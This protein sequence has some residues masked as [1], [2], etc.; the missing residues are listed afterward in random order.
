MGGHH[1]QSVIVF[2]AVHRVA[3][4]VKMLTEAQVV[5]MTSVDVG[6]LDLSQ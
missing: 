3:K 2:I 1:G 6:A 5:P 4:A